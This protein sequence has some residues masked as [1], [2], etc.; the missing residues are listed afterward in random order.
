MKQSKG[1]RL[2]YSI[3]SIFIVA[4]GL[5]SRKFSAYLPSSVNDYLGDALWAS[6]IFFLF[7]LLFSFTRNKSKPIFLFSLSLIFCYAIELSQFY[8]EEWIDAIRATTLGGLVLGFGFL[9][10]DIIAYT[11][12]VSAAAIADFFIRVPTQKRRNE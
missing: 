9:W 2:I 3:I 8:H 5:L 10:S 4:A 7:A 1:S 12:G 6:L 11:I